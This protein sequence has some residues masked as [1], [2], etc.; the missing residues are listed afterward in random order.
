MD[1]SNHFVVLRR[2]WNPPIG[3]TAGHY[4]ER[5]NGAVKDAEQD[6]KTEIAEDDF[7]CSN[8]RRFVKGY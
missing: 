4:I 8:E 5:L 1:A 2:E 6:Y 7:Y 3:V